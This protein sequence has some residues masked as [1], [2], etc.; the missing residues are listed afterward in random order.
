MGE[1]WWDRSRARCCDCGGESQVE[2]GLRG[3]GVLYR[4]HVDEG[5]HAREG[6]DVVNVGSATSGEV[7]S[8]AWGSRVL[9]GRC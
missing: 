4:L 8:V 6:L 1:R 9:R 7:G 3:R 2:C 5:A